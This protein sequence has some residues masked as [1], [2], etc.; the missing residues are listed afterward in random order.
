MYRFQ[1]CL[2][3]KCQRAAEPR[4]SGRQRAP[5]VPRRRRSPGTFLSMCFP[6]GAIAKIIS[7]CGIAK[8]K[9]H[10][11]DSEI[12]RRVRHLWYSGGKKKEKGLKFKN[13]NRETMRVSGCRQTSLDRINPT[14][15]RPITENRCTCRTQI[16]LL[17][18]QSPTVWSAGATPPILITRYWK[19]YIWS[20]NYFCFS[21]PGSFLSP[22]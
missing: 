21:L 5:I 16:H 1:K 3:F 14:P 11:C 9:P 12:V 2:Q 10:D 19:I 4:E 18:F 7:S 13:E 8:W 22:H 6:F 20:F 17:S 15:P